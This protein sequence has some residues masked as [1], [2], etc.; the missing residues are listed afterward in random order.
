MEEEW[1]MAQYIYKGFKV[2]YDIK[3][4]SGSTNLYKAD[5][6]VV[7]CL[8]KKGLTPPQKFHTEYRTKTEVQNEIRRLLENYVDFEWK[9]FHEM[10]G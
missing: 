5:G 2:F 3:P 7:C 9:E 6:Y 8:D 10:H 1:Q 4:V